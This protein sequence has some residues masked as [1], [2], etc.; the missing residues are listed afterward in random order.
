MK[1]P[2]NIHFIIFLLFISA[3]RNLNN[4]NN[5]LNVELFPTPIDYS[6]PNTYL[7]LSLQDQIMDESP[8][9]GTSII[10]LIENIST[11]QIWFSDKDGYEIFIISEDE[12][13]RIED[14]GSRE[15]LGGIFL[16]PEGEG[17]WKTH[18]SVIPDISNTVD[19]VNIIIKLTGELY[20]SGIGSG[21][22]VTATLELTLVP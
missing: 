3:C 9:I 13:I 11:E 22:Y 4:D 19:S 21:N 7:R 8:K 12:E 1:L 6:I 20:Y 15:Y 14:K 2:K 10:F 5:I 16:Q 18:S 17:R